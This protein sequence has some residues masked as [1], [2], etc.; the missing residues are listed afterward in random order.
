MNPTGNAELDNLQRKELQKELDRLKRNS[1]RRE[2]R[3]K[4]KGIGQAG[5]PTNAGSPAQSDADATTPVKGGRGRPKDGT[6]RKCANC[7]MVGHIKTNRKSVH[8]TFYCSNRSCA[9]YQGDAAAVLD[10]SVALGEGAFSYS[11]LRL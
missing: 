3:E 9:K 1:D 4:Q 10:S 7:G 2:A 11:A 6:Q 5:S 8:S